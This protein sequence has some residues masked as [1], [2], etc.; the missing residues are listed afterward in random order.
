MLKYKYIIRSLIV[1]TLFLSVNHAFSQIKISPQQIVD[2]LKVT[3]ARVYPIRVENLDTFVVI[4]MNPIVIM[5][6]RVFKSRRER[7]RYTRL[8]YNVKKVYP[9]AQIINEIYAEVERDLANIEDKREQRRYVKKREKELKEK[10]EKRLVNLTIT[11]GRILIKL[12]D[13]E[14]GNTTYEV[15]KELKG[16]MSA[17]FW[18]SIAIVFGS[19]LKSEYDENEEDKMI[20]EIIH[21]IENGQI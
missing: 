12:V 15:V 8:M 21:M 9:Y 7:R 20:E 3:N 4:N 19:N 16:S 11:Q 17:F 6:K 2:S 13:R 10:F 18:Q 1:L 5:P 14:T